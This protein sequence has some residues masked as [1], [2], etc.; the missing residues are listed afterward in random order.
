MGIKGI[1]VIGITCSWNEKRSSF[2]I[3]TDYVRSV[4]EA[5][6]MPLMIPLVSKKLWP[7]LLNR[8][9]GLI[10]SGGE[11]V[12]SLN[13]REEPLPGQGTVH[14]PRDFQELYLARRALGKKIPLLGICRGMQLLNIAA[15]GTIYQDLDSQREG[16]IQHMQTAP[17][18]FAT[19]TVQ[20]RESTALYG[21]LG[22]SCLRVNSFHHQAVKV[23]APGFKV[24]ALSSDNIVEAMERPGHPFAVAVQWHPE[25]LRDRSSAVL[26]SALVAAASG[27]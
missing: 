9:G 22:E 13:F 23:T 2:F 4:E 20:L 26:F 27:G 7:A 14:P 10:F 6:G 8:V 25:N 12:G 3:G 24:S 19:H 21:L 5:G 16:V 17:R 11:D 18:S 15:G 1:P